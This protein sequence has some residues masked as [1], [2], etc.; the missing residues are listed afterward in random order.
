MNVSGVNQL[1]MNYDEKKHVATNSYVDKTTASLRLNHFVM[2]PVFKLMAK[3][4]KTLPNIDRLL[5]QITVLFERSK[6]QLGERRG[7]RIY[8]EGWAIRRLCGVGKK[9]IYRAA[10]PKDPGFENICAPPPI[11]RCASHI[12]VYACHFFH[13]SFWMYP[14]GVI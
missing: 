1:L 4:E 11:Y 5:Q 9:L 7:D 3:N 6:L 14:E 12:I 8:Q 2:S 13:G 10:L